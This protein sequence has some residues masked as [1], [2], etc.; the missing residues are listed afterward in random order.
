MTTEIAGDGATFCVFN[1][2]VFD[3]PICVQA[4]DGRL[5]LNLRGKGKADLRFGGVAIPKLFFKVIVWPEKAKLRVAAFVVTQEDLLVKLDRLRQTKEVTLLEA[6]LNEDEVRLYQVQL[7]DLEHV[8]Q[9][10][11]GKLT[12]LPAPAMEESTL[13]PGLNAPIASEE[14]IRFV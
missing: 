9:I 1:G 7:A 11:F 6:G 14:E 5:H 13:T 2:P 4:D 3:A 12:K 10:N 8:T